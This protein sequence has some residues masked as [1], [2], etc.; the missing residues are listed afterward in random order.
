MAKI[1]KYKDKDKYPLY[2]YF[3]PATLI[4]W[5]SIAGRI[6]SNWYYF[7]ALMISHMWGTASYERT[8]K[9][10]KDVK[11]ARFTYLLMGIMLIAFVSFSTMVFR[12]PELIQKY[13]G[14]I[15]GSE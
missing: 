15:S 14:P 12:N 1:T 11:A 9:L 4:V 13:L 10:Y 6:S 8:P 2:L 7:G 3:V 5:F